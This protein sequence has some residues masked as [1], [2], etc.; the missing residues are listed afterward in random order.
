[1]YII[2]I[3]FVFTLQSYDNYLDFQDKNRE[4]L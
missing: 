4:N 3:S 1:M 2:C